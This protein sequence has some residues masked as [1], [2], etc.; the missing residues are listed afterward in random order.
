MKEYRSEISQVSNKWNL[1]NAFTGRSRFKRAMIFP[2]S[3]VENAQR[4]SASLSRYAA[5]KDSQN[6]ERSL[7]N[8]LVGLSRV[9]G[10]QDR[11]GLSWP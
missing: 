7:V 6:L 2:Y 1:Q 3:C 4:G 8:E 9:I 11:D 10:S 5:R